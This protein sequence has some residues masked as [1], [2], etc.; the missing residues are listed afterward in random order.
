M[1]NG[2][3]FQQQAARMAERVQRECGSDTTACVRRALALV[4][5]RPPSEA[6]VLRGTGLIQTL[7]NSDGASAS[8][9]LTSFCLLALNLNEF[10]YLD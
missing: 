1:L 6:E 3:F 8:D 4:M 10:L 2:D 5:S 9:A 7:E